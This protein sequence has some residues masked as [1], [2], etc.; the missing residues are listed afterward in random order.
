MDLLDFQGSYK[1]LFA[2][3]LK[4]YN[5][6]PSADVKPKLNDQEHVV[7]W[8]CMFGLSLSLSLSLRVSLWLMFSRYSLGIRDS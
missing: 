8:Q 5:F 7:P 1:I 4:V 2:V 3:K 6:L